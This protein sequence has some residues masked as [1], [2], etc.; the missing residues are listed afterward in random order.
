MSR[1]VYIQAARIADNEGVRINALP[2]VPPAALCFLSSFYMPLDYEK[3]QGNCRYQGGNSHQGQ[4]FVSVDVQDDD[5]AL[6]NP[7]LT[8]FPVENEIPDGQTIPRDA[9]F[10]ITRKDGGIVGS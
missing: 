1:Q 3:R 7:N 4:T 5:L 2:A 9:T 8:N 10:V 6:G